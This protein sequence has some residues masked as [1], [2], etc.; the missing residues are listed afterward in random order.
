[1]VHAWWSYGC[2]EAHQWKQVSSW[3]RALFYVFKWDLPH[4]DNGL[5]GLPVLPKAISLVVQKARL[6]A[7]AVSKSPRYCRRE[8]S[9]ALREIY[10]AA[11]TV[12][13]LHELKSWCYIGDVLRIAWYF[14]LLFE[15][16][17]YVRLGHGF[18]CNDLPS[19]PSLNATSLLG[20]VVKTLPFRLWEMYTWP[21]TG[22][23]SDR[24]LTTNRQT[25]GRAGE[26]WGMKGV[27]VFPVVLFITECG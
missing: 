5:S 26:Q 16:C 13:E 18:H 2:Q 4:N 17:Q 10:T 9:G 12:G 27:A 25:L 14:Q 22:R 20:V 6:L 7:V 15:Q 8:N 21:R 19:F 3:P 23:I 11:W 1:M 24:I